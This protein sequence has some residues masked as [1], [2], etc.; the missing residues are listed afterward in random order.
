MLAN[1]L[2]RFKDMYPLVFV[3]L[4]RRLWLQYLAVVRGCSTSILVPWAVSRMCDR[5]FTSAQGCGGI[6]ACQLKLLQ[7]SKALMN[8]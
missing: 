2:Y 4:C 6:A 8:F 5:T 3:L 7:L 1:A